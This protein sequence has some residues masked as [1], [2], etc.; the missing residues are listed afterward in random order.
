MPEHVPAAWVADTGRHLLESTW[1]KVNLVRER[2]GLGQ[3]R[4]IIVPEN[5]Y[6][7]LVDVLDEDGQWLCPGNYWVTVLATDGP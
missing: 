5:V 1:I 2:L 7:M 6:D 3:V 4:Y